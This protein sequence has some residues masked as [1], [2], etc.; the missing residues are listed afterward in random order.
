MK[1]LLPFA[2]GTTLL[3][4]ITLASTAAQAQ[5]DCDRS[6]LANALDAYLLN[7]DFTKDNGPPQRELCRH[8]EADKVHT[9]P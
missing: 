3:A 6:C 2:L 4:S 5:S 9:A 7:I 1:P 8:P